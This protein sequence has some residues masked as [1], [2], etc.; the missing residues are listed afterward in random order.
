MD[1][2]SPALTS[3]TERGPVVHARAV[4]ADRRRIAPRAVGVA[5][6][7]SHPQTRRVHLNAHSASRELHRRYTGYRPLTP[8]NSETLARFWPDLRPTA[9]F[10]ATATAIVTTATTAGAAVTAAV[11]ASVAGVYSSPLPRAQGASWQAV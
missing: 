11:T 5:R 9:P 7:A 8:Y 4:E 2:L 3:H 10:F 1:F 6:G